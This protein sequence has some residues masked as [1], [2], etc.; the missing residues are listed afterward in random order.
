MVSIHIDRSFIGGEK[1]RYFGIYQYF[2]VGI[3]VFGKVQYRFCLI[4]FEGKMVNQV[5]KCNLIIHFDLVYIIWLKQT[6]KQQQQPLKYQFVEMWTNKWVHTY[7]EHNFLFQVSCTVSNRLWCIKH[8]KANHQEL[9]IVLFLHDWMWSWWQGK[10]QA[11]KDWNMLR[12]FH[13]ISLN[14]NLSTPM[15]MFYCSAWYTIN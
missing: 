11:N 2:S 8:I 12:W 7:T 10:C 3:P 1:Y 6:N 13:V 5:S 4:K 9:F 15:S 14:L